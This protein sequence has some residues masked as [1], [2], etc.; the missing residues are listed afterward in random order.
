MQN[1]AKE[2]VD[3][4]VKPYVDNFIYLDRG[5]DSHTFDPETL[6]LR[7]QVIY[8]GAPYFKSDSTIFNNTEYLFVFN[9]SVYLLVLLLLLKQ[10]NLSFSSHINTQAVILQSKKLG[11]LV[12]KE[13]RIK[14]LGPIYGTSGMKIAYTHTI[15][16]HRKFKESLI[17]FMKLNIGESEIISKASLVNKDLHNVHDV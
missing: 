3:V 6:T 2:I 16:K 12:V 15:E 7:G 8:N 5:F 14:F 9:Q 17:L 11:G 13:H 10:H 4:I 1:I